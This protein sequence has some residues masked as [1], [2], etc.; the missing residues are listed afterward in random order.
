MRPIVPHWHLIALVVAA[1]AAWTSPLSAQTANPPIASSSF[2]IPGVETLDEDAC[3]VAPSESTS[4]L[5]IYLH[6]IVP[7]DATS[8]IKT[9]FETV[10]KN[11]VERAHVTALLP[12]GK[13]GI[14]PPGHDKWWAWPTTSSSYDRYGAEL[15]SKI[16]EKRAQLEARLHRH[17]DR[18][19]LAGS[20]SG[21][22]FVSALALRGGLAVDG[23]AALSGGAPFWAPKLAS[24][25]PRPF[26]IGYG[27]WD[28]VRGSCTLLAAQLRRSHWP[29]RVS[30]FEKTG[31]GAREVYL[32][33]AF[34][35]WAE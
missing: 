15:A 33:E 19:Y 31:H 24:L 17:F 8:G 3:Y 10:L 22:Y 21:A 18:V 28:T 25:P 4:T 5:L 14:A 35:F 12:R 23:Y 6:G 34:A 27:L 11:A 32:D 26:Y 29:V 30:E 1:T 13:Q 20:S 16:V 9:R 7:P 2:C